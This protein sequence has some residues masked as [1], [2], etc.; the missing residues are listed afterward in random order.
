MQ[1]GEM[2]KPAS[3]RSL[4]GELLSV[5]RADDSDNNNTIDQDS[6]SCKA[7]LS[8]G[9]TEFLLKKIIQLRACLQPEFSLSGGDEDQVH[10]S[11]EG[12]MPLRIGPTMGIA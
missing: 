11:A 8:E 9:L 12:Q 5:T 3:V 1:S 2:E 4:P 10:Q 7:E 6:E